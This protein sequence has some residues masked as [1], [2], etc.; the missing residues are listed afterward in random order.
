MQGDEETICTLSAAACIA[1]AKPNMLGHT[2]I[3]FDV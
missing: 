2:L 1:Q 3:A